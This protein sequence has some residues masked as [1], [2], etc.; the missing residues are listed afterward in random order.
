M[1]FAPGFNRGSTEFS[2]FH[3]EMDSEELNKYLALLG[4][5]VA[6]EQARVEAMVKAFPVFTKTQ[7]ERHINDIKRT[8][9]E[10]PA[11]TVIDSFPEKES[12]DD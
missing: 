11:V 9:Q 5:D 10:K 3:L 4:I 6:N 7:V 2:P 8:L 1:I 12:D